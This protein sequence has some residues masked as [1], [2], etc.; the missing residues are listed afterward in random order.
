MV[1]VLVPRHNGGQLFGGGRHA[2][3]RLRQKEV[4]ARLVEAGL[5]PFEIVVEVKEDG[6]GS[7]TDHPPVLSTTTTATAAAEWLA[8]FMLAN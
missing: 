7:E 2:I 3:A 8:T 6:V 1:L 5:A 4:G